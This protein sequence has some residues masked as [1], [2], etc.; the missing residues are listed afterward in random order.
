MGSAGGGAC[1]GEARLMG[2]V[3]KF[4][5]F[6]VVRASSFESKAANLRWT[7]RREDR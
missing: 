1:D 7:S 5:L 3:R 6:G 2:S 4:N